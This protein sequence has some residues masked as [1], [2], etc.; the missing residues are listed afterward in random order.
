MDILAPLVYLLA[1]IL[2]IFA[3]RGLSHPETAR[4][5]LTYGMVGMALAILG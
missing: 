3:L 1:A 4:R 2:F 5:G